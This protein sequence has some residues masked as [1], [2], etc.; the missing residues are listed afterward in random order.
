MEASILT[1]LIAGC[2][3]SL[4]VHHD[5][6]T[7]TAFALAGKEW[8]EDLEFAGYGRRFDHESLLTPT[9]LLID[10]HAT[11]QLFARAGSTSALD[12][13]FELLAAGR[14]QGVD[15]WCHHRKRIYFISNKHSNALGLANRRHALRAGGIRRHHPYEP[16]REVLSDGLNLARAMSFK[17]AAAQIPY[18]GG[19]ICIIADPIATDDLEALGFL[20]W[21][22]DRSRC[23]TG[24][25]MGLSPKHA[26]ALRARFTKNIVGGREGAL[27]PTGTP[28]AEGLLVA[29]GEVVR[30]HLQADGLAGLSVA[31]QG[32]GAVGAPLGRGLLA[33]GVSRLLVA[34]IHPEAVDDFLAGLEPEQKD[35]VEVVEP[36]ALLFAKVDIVSPNAVGGVLGPA[37]IEQL[38]C[39]VVMGAA[40]NQLRAVSQEQELELAERLHRRGI[41]F[42]VDW[43]H[44]MAGVIAGCE[45]WEHQEQAS[46]ERVTAALRRVCSTGVR[47]NLE[48]AARHGVTPTAM[49][50][51]RIEQQIYGESVSPEP[52]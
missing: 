44:N 35:R 18:G 47:E 25:D 5:W 43:M 13:L 41:V 12:G 31:V 8:E 45:E 3:T 10:R 14:H 30:H 4:Q 38:R 24:P 50:Y 9:P 17:N 39:R 28:T 51:R 20:A 40:N 36:A 7:G 2:L 1:P 37:E 19:K 32:L 33:A 49:A 48:L 22:I 16:E 23:F 21:C 29:L 6:R 34:D 15:I 46:M 11:R 27:G 26:D 42:Q 52:A